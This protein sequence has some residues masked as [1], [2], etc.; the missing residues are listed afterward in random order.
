M[1]NGLT[2]IGKFLVIKGL[3]DTGCHLV[4]E[5]ALEAF[6]CRGKDQVCVSERR[7]VG[8]ADARKSSP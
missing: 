8:R 4:G 6:S 3:E 1:R 5:G 7:L 2:G